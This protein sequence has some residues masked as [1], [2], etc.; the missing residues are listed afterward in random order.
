MRVN[1]VAFAFAALAACATPQVANT[2]TANLTI[3]IAP[4]ATRIVPSISP[5]P[6]VP[7]SP[8]LPSVPTFPSFP[9]LTLSPSLKLPP[10]LIEIAR[11]FGYPDDLAL[12]PDGTI[13]FSDTGNGT[14]NHIAPNG[15]VTTLVRGLIEPEGI[16]VLMDSSLIFVE[17]GKNRLLHFRPHAGQPMTTWLDLENKTSNAGV[18]NILRDPKTGDLIIP[19]SPNGRI[20]RVTPEKKISVIAAGLARPVGADIERDGSL[21]VADEFGNAVKRIRADGRIETLGPFALPDDVAVDADGNI[22]VASLTDNSLRMIAARTG[23]TVLIANIRSPQGLIL[24]AEGNLIATE[25]GLNRIVR[26]KI[27]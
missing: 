2:P 22:F 11:G 8:T 3:P 27:R 13:Y 15:T 26:I 23:A 18:D 24:D 17:Q 7:S 25:S 21:V 20:L 4:T 5:P 14:I 12:A 1:Y 6:T 10:T 16:V 19:D 9:S